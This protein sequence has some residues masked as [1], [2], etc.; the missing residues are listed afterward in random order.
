MRQNQ[1]L[2]AR[3][4]LDSNEEDENEDIADLSP[5]DPASRTSEPSRNPVLGE[6]P[7]F[8]PLQPF[9]V[10]LHVGEAANTAFA[11]RFRQH[12]SKTTTHHLPR[13]SYP[14]DH[15]SETS[16]EAYTLQ[17]SLA[18]ARFLV[19]IGLASVDQ[20]YH[21]VRKKTIWAILEQFMETPPSLDIFLRCKILAIFALGELHSSHRGS[22]GSEGTPGLAYY[23]LAC[24]AYGHLVERPCVDSIEV[25]LLLVSLALSGQVVELNQIL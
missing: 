10:P 2:R 5:Y 3:L 19:Q 23:S 22:S 4:R 7:W 24:K 12:I 13:L 9:N 11:T 1:L 17:L 6:N 20:C 15:Q 21:I 25:F 18:Q 14:S 16:A 8:L